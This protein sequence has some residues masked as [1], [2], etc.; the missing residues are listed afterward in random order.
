[1][2]LVCYWFSVVCVPLFSSFPIVRFGVLLFS[3][4]PLRHVLLGPLCFSIGSPFGFYYVPPCFSM[5]PFVFLLGPPRFLLFSIG[6]PRFSIGFPSAFY[7]GGIL[8]QVGHH[9]G[10]LC[11]LDPIPTARPFPIGG[12]T[13][14]GLMF[15]LIPR[16]LDNIP[17]TR[18]HPNG[19][20][21]SRRQDHSR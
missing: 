7:I 19:K 10:P 21:T 5:A 17:T 3:I 20:T 8:E 14:R 6:L 12:Q 9:S 18:Q 4:A 2:P 13:L 11:R 1:M 16:R 15:F